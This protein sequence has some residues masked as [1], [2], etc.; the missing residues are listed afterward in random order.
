MLIIK[1]H[2]WTG[3]SRF[4]FTAII[5]F[6]PSLGKA[7]DFAF[8][9]NGK[10]IEQATYYDQKKDYL[11][12]PNQKILDFSPWKNRLYAD[13]NFNLKRADTKF[14]S[15]FRPMIVSDDHKTRSRTTVDDLY[16]D[17]KFWDQIFF[18][19][20]KR[21]I[22]D[23]VALGFNPTD[24]L[25]EGKEV[26]FSKRE[27]DRRVEREGNY[28][29]GADAFFKDAAWTVIFAPQIDDW[30]DEKDRALLKASY[31]LESFN[32]DVSV[33]YFY[34]D[35][36]GAGVNLSHTANDE[37]VLYTE[38][39]LR[40][41]TNKKILRLE[42]PASGGVYLADK[43]DNSEIFLR[44]AVGGHYTFKNSAN[45]I[46]E[47]I[48]NADGYNQDKWDEFERVV[49]LSND[50]WKKGIFLDSASGNLSGA[51]QTMT[52]RQMRKNYLFFRV[53]HPSVF[54]KVDGSLV[55]FLN[56]DDMSFLI[57]PSV[58]YKINQSALIG[59]SSNIFAGSKTK[60]FGM[61]HWG[62][63]VTLTYK[64]YF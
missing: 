1:K 18:Y 29:V 24:F 53:N 38:T 56:L 63:D 45:I 10:V 43:M 8:E 54:S 32:T 62:K 9:F 33:H 60:E 27:E 52:F 49:S 22:K 4:V 12:N 26:D 3:W 7:Q 31:F 35:I 15:K 59:L 46:C 19:L 21:N 40:K 57:N 14:I 25:G 55:L 47:Y 50:Q 64:H 16:I 28:L 2:L 61:M 39:A 6:I 51:N 23:G 37:L 11:L 42:N 48:Y 41:G 44:A 34:G 13:I 17:Q 5:A 30:Q 58:E 36:P 20:G